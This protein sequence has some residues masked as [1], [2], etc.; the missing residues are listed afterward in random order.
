M[1]VLIYTSDMREQDGQVMSAEDIKDN[2]TDVQDVANTLSWEN[3]RDGALDEYHMAEG[4]PLKVVGD[5]YRHWPSVKTHPDWTYVSEVHVNLR[6]GNGVF[7]VGSVSYDQSEGSINGHLSRGDIMI[8][9]DGYGLGAADGLWHLDAADAVNAFGGSNIV[10]A[11]QAEEA[12]P[13][14]ILLAHRKDNHPWYGAAGND[15]VVRGQLVVF[16]VDR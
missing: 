9:I 5:G 1:G 2:L 11:F 6:A 15:Y 8:K 10:Y 4:E 7:I 12:G 16:V 14:R 13:R 3:F